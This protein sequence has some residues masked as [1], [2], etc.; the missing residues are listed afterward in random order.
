MQAKDQRILNAI[1]N[2]ATYKAVNVYR[3]R[4]TEDGKELYRGEQ[5]IVEDKLVGEDCTVVL[6][7]RANGVVFEWW[8]GAGRPV[9]ER[10]SEAEVM[11]LSANSLSPMVFDAMPD[12]V[13]N[14]DR[15]DA[16]FNVGEL[17]KWL[18]ARVFLA[19][20]MH[21][22]AALRAKRAAACGIDLKYI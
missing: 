5:V 7:D 15:W 4:I 12:T 9:M 18:D 13:F 19:T 21:K 3:E 1:C 11:A 16:K 20:E 10:G 8:Q 2:G 6:T 22:S 14:G 17:K